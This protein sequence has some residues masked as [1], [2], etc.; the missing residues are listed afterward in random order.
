MATGQRAFLAVILAAGLA[1]AGCK[2]FTA[3]KTEPL[4]DPVDT[5]DPKVA[6]GEKLFFQHCHQCHPHGEA[7]LGPAIV[8]KPLPEFLMKF[9]VRHGLGTMPS[10]GGDKIPQADLDDLMAYLKA[11]RGNPPDR[12]AQQPV[13]K[14][15][16]NPS[17]QR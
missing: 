14:V 4:A 2:A 8:N 3:R 7:G 12:Q 16:F 9:Q 6:H 11:V 1:L 17:A 15:S 10:F 5:S 13:K